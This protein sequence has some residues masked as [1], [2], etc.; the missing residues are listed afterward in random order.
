MDQ[1]LLSASRRDKVGK[2]VKSIRAEGKL[3]AIIYGKG[4]E[5]VAISLDFRVASKVLR[6]V[7]RASLLNIDVDGETFN[8][9][10]R[11]RQREVISGDLL[12]V[13]FLAISLTEKVRTEINI[14]IEGDAPAV[15]DFGAVL[16][17]GI[18]RLEVEC[19]PTDLPDAIRV[20]VSGLESIGDGL[21]LKEISIP[22][23][24]EILS[25]LEEMVVFATAPQLEEEE[26]EEEL[27]E[28]LLE[29]G[30][31]PEVIEKG[32]QEDEEESEE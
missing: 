24:I 19:L 11:D 12:H 22:D 16:V 29:E 26:E 20:D 27:D 28:E 9:L 3:P 25:D 14:I 4:I 30:V 32:K 31:E 2:K 17:T 15:A 21:Y 8:A 10:V 23:E 6:D 13:D 7:S 18:D 5:P 1:I